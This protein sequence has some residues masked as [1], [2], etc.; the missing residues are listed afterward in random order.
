VFKIVYIPPEE[1]PEPDVPDL[2]C[3]GSLSWTNVHPG[4]TVNGSFQVLNIGG[5]DSLL[6]WTI[7]VSSLDWGTWSFTPQF[8]I[9]LTPGDGQVT[10]QV[11]VV[12]PNQKNT[13]FEGYV[14]VENRENSTDFHVIP[15]YLKTPANVH[16]VQTM[17]HSFLIKLKQR[18]F[19][20]EKIWNLF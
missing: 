14:R 8:G 9:N 7:N 15:V 13:K 11:S 16:S 5:P 17:I 2:D 4:E 6:N 3:T 12:A 1:P 10:V 18:H 19:L 20:F